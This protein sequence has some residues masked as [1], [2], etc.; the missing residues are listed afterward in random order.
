[1]SFVYR[2]RFRPFDWFNYGLIAAMCLVCLFPFY[3]VL[4]VSF[5][6]PD[7]YVPLRLYL[8]PPRFSL[9][10]YEFILGTPT[11]P[12]AVFNTIF[13]TVV[14]TAVNLFVTFTFAY[15]LTRR[16][17]PGHR[18]LSVLVVFFLIFN[19]G[20]VPNYL[21]IKELGLLDSLWSLIVIAAT[22]SW[23]IIVVRSFLLSIPGELQE[24]AVIDGC[25]DITAF[26]NVI[27]PL[28]LPCI[29]AFLLF[30]AVAHWN[31]YFDAMLYLQD[32]RRWTLQVLVKSIV[33][34]ANSIDLGEGQIDSHIPP[35]ETIRFAAVVLAMAPI[36][37]LYPFLQKYFVSGIMVGA[38]KG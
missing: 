1:M 30:F 21:L 2:N 23:S 24:A 28:S 20:M 19:A 32:A 26:S 4:M 16:T 5:I 8:W 15:G 7:I 10:S 31:M 12:H 36:V 35:Q 18:V 17:M 9:R 38:L 14:G 33:I 11:F 37:A 25:N 29:S 27:V 3:Y 34:Q 22:N 13:V 6:D